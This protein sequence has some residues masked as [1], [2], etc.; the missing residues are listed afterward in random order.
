[1]EEVARQS[2]LI[3]RYQRLHAELPQEGATKKLAAATFSIRSASEIIARPAKPPLRSGLWGELAALSIPANGRMDIVPGEHRKRRRILESFTGTD[4]VFYSAGFGRIIQRPAHP[5][6]R[7]DPRGSSSTDD[8]SGVVA[9][10]PE[11][12]IIFSKRLRSS[13][14]FWCPD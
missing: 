5:H 7:I 4:S 13:M 11:G 12:R 3:K 14:S 8:R 6:S 1:M 9:G 2:E 10:L